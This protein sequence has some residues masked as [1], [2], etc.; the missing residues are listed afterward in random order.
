MRQSN[1]ELC[2][3]AAIL[4]V[5]L[6]HSGFQT[7]GIPQTL[8][9]TSLPLLML[10][11]FSIIGVNVF[12]LITGYFSAKPKVKSLVNVTYICLFFAIVS[13]L[14]AY[15]IGLPFNPKKLF[16]ISRSNWFIPCYLCL[17]FFAPFLNVA[18]ENMSQKQ[19]LGGVISFFVIS[20]WIGFFPAI[21]Q[22]N[23]GFGE[24]YSVISFSL[25]YL[26]G[27]YIRLYG[28]PK[29]F[30][31]YSITIYI[32]CSLSIGFIAYGVLSLG[33]LTDRL[34][35]LSY[36]YN[37]PIVIISAV[38]F[39]SMFQRMQ[40]SDNKVINYF[41]QSTLAVLLVHGCREA[42]YF[43]VPH[44]KYLL[45]NYDGILCILLWAVS[46]LVIA[47]CGLLIDQIRIYSYK[48]IGPRL[49]N[50]IEKQVSMIK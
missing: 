6:V 30:A 23:P 28:L 19:L 49:V 25:I 42:L 7:F 32:L 33:L 21:S 13:V 8:E 35:N 11:S 15:L 37:N 29:W 36:A 16:F 44:F 9:D 27:R 1:I 40:I 2:R 48:L 45:A 3:I 46:I 20:T 22:I 26:I 31:K 47:L 24:G 18:C 34:I 10:Q 50:I 14:S 38:A 17:L 41:A 5:V 43:T 12:V 39:F 4:L